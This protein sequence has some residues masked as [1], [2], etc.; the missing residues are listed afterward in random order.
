[1][2]GCCVG[3]VGQSGLADQWEQDQDHEDWFLDSTGSRYGR[4]ATTGGGE[5]IHLPG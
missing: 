5:P 3:Q 4:T 2:V 1:M